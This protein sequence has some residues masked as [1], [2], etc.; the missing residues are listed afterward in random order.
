MM[1]ITHDMVGPTDYTEV[2][3]F[4]TCAVLFLSYVILSTGVTL[5]SFM[6]MNVCLYS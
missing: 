6:Y 3:K 4:M 1:Y 2:S 5:L